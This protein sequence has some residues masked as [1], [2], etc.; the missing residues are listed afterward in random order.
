VNLTDDFDGV[1][2]RALLVA[3]LNHLA[4]FLLRG[5]EQFTFAG[6]LAGRFFYID[7]LAR[8][9]AVNSERGV[10]V[11]GRG[12][13]DGVDVLRLKGFAEVALRLGG[14]AKRFFSIGG[15]ASADFVVRVADV[16]DVRDLFVGLERGKV[17]VSA[18]VEAVDGKVEPIVGAE[19]LSIA[20]SR[21][22][23]CR[24]GHTCSNSINKGSP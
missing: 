13:G 23:E 19:D 4:V 7:M 24:A 2:R 9:E 10:P 22:G 20:F 17:R 21:S 5:D 3:N 15:K 16:G 6:V 1:R 18:T 14:I 11:V 8:L 12:D